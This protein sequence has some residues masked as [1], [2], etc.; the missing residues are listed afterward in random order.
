[1]I[2]LCS[3]P[4][5][6]L[7]PLLQQCWAARRPSSAAASRLHVPA[8]AVPPTQ[9]TLLVP[10][11]TGPPDR[12][13]APALEVF[14]SSSLSVAPSVCAALC[15]IAYIWLV[16]RVARIVFCFLVHRSPSLG[17]EIVEG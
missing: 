13:A 8:C 2:C 14:S 6:P 9:N 16:L 3:Q 7:L 10:P 12:P 15:S 5:L 1:M 11:G 17:C 4:P